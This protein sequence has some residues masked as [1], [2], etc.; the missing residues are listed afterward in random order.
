MRFPGSKGLSGRLRRGHQFS[1]FFEPELWINT[2]I[3]KSSRLSLWNLASSI[4]FDSPSETLRTLFS[5]K[6][7]FLDL[8]KEFEKFGISECGQDEIFTISHYMRIGVSH[9]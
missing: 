3:N 4:S 2:G 6:K 9:F 8:E 7:M 1:I 5:M